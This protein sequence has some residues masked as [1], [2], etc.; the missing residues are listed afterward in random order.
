M[1]ILYFAP[2]YYDDMKQ[3]PQHL[4]ECLASKH[5][6]YYIEPTISLIRWMLKKG[7]SCRGYHQKINNNFTCIQLNGTFTVHK[8]IEIADVFGIN[9]LSEYLQIAKLAKKCDVI[10]V[11]YSGW[12]TLVRHLKGKPVVFDWMDEEELLVSSKILKLTL[13]R[14][15]KKLLQMSDLVFTTCIKFYEEIKDMKRTYLVPNAVSNYFFMEIPKKEHTKEEYTKKDYRQKEYTKK[16]CTQGKKQIFGY[17]G[18]IGEWFDFDVIQYILSLNQNYFIVF[19]GRNL[20]PIFRHERV[21]Y[22]GIKPYE[23]LPEFVKQ[24]DVCLYN[25]KKNDLLDTINPVKIYEYLAAGKPV[26]AVASKETKKLKKHIMLYENTEEIGVLLKNG[27]KQP[28]S[29]KKEY[30]TFVS[31]NTWE[32]RAQIIEHALYQLLPHRKE[33]VS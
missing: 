27:Y 7:K 12:Y 8:S 19:I 2:I 33:T 6:V 5:K 4:A 13:R 18:T 30:L 23:E 22:L 31:Q 11:G 10:W 1:K 28:F 15:K 26:L 25:F 32:S 14:N 3:R 9:N 24:F 21:S 20:Q 16:K 17:I 29:S